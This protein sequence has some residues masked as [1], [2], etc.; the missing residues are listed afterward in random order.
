MRQAAK[1]DSNQKAIVKSLRGIPGVTVEITSMMGKGFVDIIVGYKG[2][3]YL[4]ELKDGNKPPSQRKLTPDEDI[5]HSKWTGQKAVCN[6]F[7]EVFKIIM[8]KIGKI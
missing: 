6:S 7:E 4:V 2:V 3:N 1:I 5:W 8:G